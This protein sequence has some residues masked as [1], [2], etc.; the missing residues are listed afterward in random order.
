MDRCPA[1]VFFK[2]KRKFH[3]SVLLFTFNNDDLHHS[4]LQFQI[5]GT[6]GFLRYVVGTPTCLHAQRYKQYHLI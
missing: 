5:G 6:E 4:L 2:K 3:I 1:S